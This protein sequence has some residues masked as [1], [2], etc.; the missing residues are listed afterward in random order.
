VFNKTKPDTIT[1]TPTPL[2]TPAPGLPN[3]LVEHLNTVWRTLW[4]ENAENMLRESEDLEPI[5]RRTEEIITIMYG[6]DVAEKLPDTSLREQITKKILP[7][8]F[9]SE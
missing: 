9:G 1:P 2:V 4:G 3:D 5:K 7:D 6:K 8:L